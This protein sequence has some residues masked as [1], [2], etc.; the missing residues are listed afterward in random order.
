[1]EFETHEPEVSI[2]PLEGEEMEVELKVGI[3]SY[4]AVAEEGYEAKWAFYDWPERVLTEISQTKYIGKILIGGEECYEFSVLDFEPKKGYQL[5]SEGRTYC[6]IKGDKVVVLRSVRRPVGEVAV[7]EEVEGWEE[8]L[9]LRVGVKFYSEGDV[10]RCG[11]R[12]RYGSGPTLEE[13]TGVAEVRI[14][15]RK[16]RCLRC[17][18]VPDPARRGEQERLQAAEWYIDQEGRCVFF[19][20]YNGRGWHNLE[21]LKE[22]PKLEHEGEA[23]YLWYDCIP[24]YVLK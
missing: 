21:K 8:P 12:V 9:R 17:L 14:G 23:F 1:M 11:D 2:I 24:D 16:F 18:W 3:P 7:E 6:K 13:V 19:R 5:E 15:D 4:F 10:Y 22:C 20:R